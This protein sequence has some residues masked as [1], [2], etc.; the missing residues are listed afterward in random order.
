M[1]EFAQRERAAESSSKNGYIENRPAKSAQTG[2]FSGFVSRAGK[3]LASL[4]QL[5]D[6]HDSSFAGMHIGHDFCK[7]RFMDTSRKTMLPVSE[8][9]NGPVQAKL[10]INQPGD[11]YEQEA[12]RIA[13]QVMAM[14]ADIAARGMPQRIQRFS[15][16]SKAEIDAA[17]GSVNKALASPGKPLDPLLQQDMEQ[18]FGH[19]FSRVRVHS[20]KDAEQSAREVSAH[21][22]TVGQNIVFGLGRFAPG[23]QEGRRLIAHELTHVVQQSGPEGFGIKQNHKKY[24]RSSIVAANVSSVSPR[25]QRENATNSLNVLNKDWLDLKMAFDKANSLPEKQA[26]VSRILAF[27]DRVAGVLSIAKGSSPPPATPTQEEIRELLTQIGS[28]LSANNLLKDALEVAKKSADPQVQQ[29]IILNAEPVP[30]VASV[31][32]EQEFLKA[33]VSYISPNTPLPSKGTNEKNNQW[34]QNR[35]ERIGQSLGKLSD[36]G[37]MDKNGVPLGLHLSSSLMKTLFSTS[38]EDVHPAA[39]GNIGRLNEDENGRLLADCDVEARYAMRLLV[40]QGWTPVGY[41]MIMPVDNV[42]HAVALARKGTALPYTYVGASSGSFKPLGSFNAD[43]AILDGLR[44]FALQVYGSGDFN[45][46]AYYLAAAN[47]EYPPMLNDPVNNRLTPVFHV[48]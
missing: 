10:T 45:Y 36:T 18:R 29:K 37:L 46:S 7:I 32:S 43:A 25:I 14:P 42:A 2:P 39:G 44:T 33:V 27:A 11:R 16:Q 6:Q 23:T 13:D 12:E 30:G 9:G 26:V 35:T 5:S 41:M 21:A 8:P 38:A 3:A 48:P 17:P 22:Y 15:G 19:D 4:P 40:A 47:G 24:G 28:M 1:P 31:E 20:D 34:L